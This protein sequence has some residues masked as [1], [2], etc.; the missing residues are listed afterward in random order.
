MAMLSKSGQLAGFATLARKLQN[1]RIPVPG[2]DS[3]ASTGKF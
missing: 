1:V 2:V 3:L